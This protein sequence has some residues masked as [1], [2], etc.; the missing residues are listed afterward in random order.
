MKAV[1]M[2]SRGGPEALVYEDAPLPTLA[3]GEALVKVRAA[4][5]TPTEFT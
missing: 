5:I 3:E 4:G 1:R 2:H